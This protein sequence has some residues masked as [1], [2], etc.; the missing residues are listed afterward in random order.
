MLK[1]TKLILQY[2]L[3]VYVIKIF[4]F[5]HTQTHYKTSD[6]LL[7]TKSLFSIILQLQT[8]KKHFFTWLFPY[9]GDWEFY[10]VGRCLHHA[11]HTGLVG[12]TDG[13]TGGVFKHRDKTLGQGGLA[14]TKFCPDLDLH[15]LKNPSHI[16]Y[17]ILWKT[18]RFI[19]QY[20][21]F[22]YRCNLKIIEPCPTLSNMHSSVL[23]GLFHV[24]MK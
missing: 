18:D 2:Q 17:F 1:Y 23:T 14:V 16:K 9:F 7:L 12:Q 3:T 24:N 5:T 15:F 11:P 8:E 4:S 21:K 10:L 22:T 6:V 13:G 20:A 19:N